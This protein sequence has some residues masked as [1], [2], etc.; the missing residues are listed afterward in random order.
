MSIATEVIY[1]DGVTAVSAAWLNRLQEHLAGWLN[2]QVTVAG[3]TVTVGASVDN[4]TASAYIGGQMRYVESDLSFT[5]TTET[6]GTFTVYIVGDGATDAFTL[7]VVSGAP[8]GTLTREVATVD[9]DLT[10]GA[11]T[12]LE[13]S[14][15]RYEA[16]VHDS[17]GG[18]NLMDGAGPIPHSDIANPEVG[19]DH[20][21]YIHRD[22]SR[23]FTA[24][25]EGVY[26]VA[27]TD[28]ATKEYADDQLTSGV[29]VGSLVPF[30]GP[31]A[32]S[33]WLLCDGTSYTV[34]G[35]PLLAAVLDDAYGG[36]GGTNFN[37]PDMRGK[38][39]YGKPD[40]GVGDSVGDS[41]GT[42]DHT[43]TN[44]AH[45][46]DQGLHTHS[47]TAHTHSSATTGSSGSHSHTQSS[48]TS[49]GA[50]THAGPSHTHTDGSYAVGNTGGAIVGVRGGSTTKGLMA[51]S[52]VDQASGSTSHSHSDGSYVSVSGTSSTASFSHYHYPS[53]NAKEHTHGVGAVTGTSGSGGTG[54]TSS[55]G[56]H[57]H[58]NPTT[59]SAGSH[60]HT[61][62]TTGS[63]L[64]QTN[65]NTLPGPTS[66]DGG[67]ALGTNS[68]PFVAV[69][70][71]IKADS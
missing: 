27:S 63:A 68:P 28:L 65:E 6:T 46:H 10:A 11:I 47:M 38:F 2:L 1:E 14:D 41:G 71:I 15:G 35:Y 4:D 59:A 54:S 17:R 21:Q 34:A 12:E 50:H 69:N 62:G 36:D 8:V 40:S 49:A 67:G 16:H 18:I 48:N 31:S 23:P 7:E 3:A 32:P 56:A 64:T 39:P 55:A 43:H 5:F 24:V 29:P 37:V 30:G 26:P 19:D 25:V 52:D 42:L 45:Y 61:V 33:G 58:S 66:T 70:Y 53:S 44:A 20:T 51:E 13:V 22:G 9:W 60:T 57:T